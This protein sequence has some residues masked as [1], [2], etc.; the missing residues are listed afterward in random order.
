MHASHRVVTDQHIFARNI[1]IMHEW[2]NGCV[3]TY[4]CTHL[5]FK[6]LT[7]SLREEQMGNCEGTSTASK[8]CWMRRPEAPHAAIFV[9]DHRIAMIL[10][11]LT[12]IVA[13][14]VLTPGGGT[15]DWERPFRS[16]GGGTGRGPLGHLEEGLGEAL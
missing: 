4:A 6:E 1:S 16:P 8:R 12:T 3:C 15:G 11:S 10:K 13:K 9:K 5:A 7:R 2:C 14:G